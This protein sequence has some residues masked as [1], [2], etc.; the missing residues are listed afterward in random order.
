MEPVDKPAPSYKQPHR[1]LYK[2]YSGDKL[3]QAYGRTGTLHLHGN[4]L[5]M[6]LVL[7]LLAI[8]GLLFTG[9]HHPQDIEPPIHI[10]HFAGNS[11]PQ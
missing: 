3:R 10:D 6:A 8:K 9:G 1:Q 5:E 11:S 4:S 7:D 2:T